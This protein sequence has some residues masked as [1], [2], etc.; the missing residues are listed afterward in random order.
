MFLRCVTARLLVR[1]R[2]AL[3]REAGEQ[4]AGAIPRSPDSEWA[5][6]DAFMRAPVGV[7]PPADPG[8]G[9]RLSAREAGDLPASKNR[10][11]IT[12]GT[13]RSPATR[14]VGDSTG[15]FSAGTGGVGD[16]VTR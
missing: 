15:S 12:P 8:S 2:Q 10:G 13:R 3:I 4:G 14:D 11:L 1:I 16:G 5:G 7:L 9:G 6:R